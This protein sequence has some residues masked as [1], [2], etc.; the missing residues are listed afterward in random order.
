MIF[1]VFDDDTCHFL[2]VIGILGQKRNSGLSD[3]PT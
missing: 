2:G 1:H 3:L